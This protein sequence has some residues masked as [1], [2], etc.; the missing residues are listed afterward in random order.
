M[1]KSLGVWWDG[2][3][4]GT[5]RI[6]EHGDLAFAYDALWL[7]DPD[8]RAVSFSLPKR[9]G[10]FGRRETRP[11]FA[12]LLPEEGQRVAVARAL[13]VSKANDF[14]LLEQLGGDVAGALTLWPED[15]PPPAPQGLAANAPLSDDRLLEI[16]DI[17]PTRPLL[18]GE[19]GVRLSLAG[20]QQKLPVVMINGAVALPAPG[21]P[22]THILKPPIAT[23]PST[24]ENEALALRLAAAVG[25]SAAAVEPRRTGGRP[26]LLIERYDREILADGTVRRLHQEDFCQ[27]LGVAS[28]NKYASEGGPTFPPCF[29]L[30]RRACASPAPS[31]LR[32]V[33]AA[34]F[35]VAIGNADAHGKNF[36]LLYRPDGIAFAPLY[37]LLCTAAYPGV[38]GKLAMKVAKRSTLEEFTPTTWEDFGREIGFGPAF[39]RRRAADLAQSILDAIDGVA[40]TIHAAGFDGP[41]LQRF[42]DVIRQRAR[43]VLDLGVA[44][45]GG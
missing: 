35:N 4:V 18:A 15:E 22:S 34:I 27:A 14:R 42:A 9:D 41:D 37:D 13:G 6:D 30:V 33:D 26:Y 24:T 3:R 36:S 17:L 40:Q 19:D 29:D 23:L 8:A 32:L 43:R 20:A 11:F 1:I 21:Q 5:L 25:L 12:G 38:H 45:A 10:V 39:V 16:L 28:E 2:R 7:D 31:V 44:R